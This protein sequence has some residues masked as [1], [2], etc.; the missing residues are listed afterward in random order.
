MLLLSAGLGAAGA[1]AGTLLAGAA[2]GAALAFAAAPLLLYHRVEREGSFDNDTRR[3][4]FEVV[5]AL[6]GSCIADIADKVGV[7]HSTAS[8]HLEKLSTF[9]H[10][11][12]TL[13]GNKV[14]YFVN[15]GAF[16]EDERRVLSILD[17][18][19]TRR[20]LQMVQ[21]H[22]WCYRA[23]LTTLL[24]VSSPTVNWH[25]ERLMAVGL[26][27][28]Q[29]QGRSRFLNVDRGR[30]QVLLHGL[31]EKLKPTGYDYT[32]LLALLASPVLEPAAT[33]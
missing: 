27:T 9:K 31:V 33:S 12:S 6:P 10:I 21:D 22:P 32:G 29:K 5:R 20:V 26:V 7:S 24:G 11:T 28:E 19:E 30:L 13:D 4:I 23:E 14:R 15:G 25:L 3:R 8:Y 1:A 2:E 16:S 18:Q 17:N